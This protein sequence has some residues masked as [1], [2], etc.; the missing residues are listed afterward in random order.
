MWV[1]NSVD[2]GRADDRQCARHYYHSLCRSGLLVIDTPFH[3]PFPSPLSPPLPVQVCWSLTP[4]VTS[5]SPTCGS[6]AAASATLRCV[7]GGAGERG[8]WGTWGRTCALHRPAAAAPVTTPFHTSP[9]S[10]TLPQ[11]LIVDL[12]HGLEQQTIESIGL[13]KMRKTPFIIALNK[14]R[15]DRA[16]G[17]GAAARREGAG[18][19]GGGGSVRDGQDSCTQQGEG[20]REEG[21]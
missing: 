13:L 7:L 16:W 4:P 8:A 18:G 2:G 10:P 12:M 20:G 21:E 9:H 11:V 14:V 5:P 1:G 17:G 15:G 19:D 6:A 3:S